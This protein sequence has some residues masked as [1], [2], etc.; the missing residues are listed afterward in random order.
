MPGH[1]SRRGEPFTAEAAIGTIR[2]ALL[3]GSTA[4]QPHL[5]GCSLGG[6]VA[7]HTAGRYPELVRSLVAAGC[8]TQPG[9]RSA[10]LYA[11]LIGWSDRAGEAPVRRLLG[12]EG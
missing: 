4:G 11:R 5:V 6:M 7:I 9:A 10:G 12:E 8:S 1:G 2:T 3:E